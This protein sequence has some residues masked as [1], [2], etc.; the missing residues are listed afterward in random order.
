[1][2][3]TIDHEA[4]LRRLERQNGRLRGTILALAVLGAGP[5]LMASTSQQAPAGVLRARALEVVGP[6]GAVVVRIDSSGPEGTGALT[7]LDAQGNEVVELSAEKD[8]PDRLSGSLE[9]KSGGKRRLGCFSHG[10]AGRVIITDED[11]KALAGIYSPSKGE[12][13]VG[14][15]DAETGVPLSALHSKGRVGQVHTWNA[16]GELLF[17]VG[18]E[19]KGGGGLL[20][21][22][23]GDKPQLTASGSGFLQIWNE[24]GQNLVSLM[25]DEKNGYLSALDPE[26][27]TPVAVLGGNGEIGGLEIMNRQGQKL[28]QITSSGDYGAVMTYSKRGVP[29]IVLASAA[30]VR[31]PKFAICDPEG[32]EI[33]TA[34]LGVVA[35][36]NGRARETGGGT[37]GVRNPHTGMIEFLGY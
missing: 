1:M 20:A 12:A 23:K 31:G 30:Q 35:D 26:T 5:F 28:V 9:L 3:T 34:G 2:N 8:G 15:F 17:R 37:V 13:F 29:G 14:V 33:V 25:C 19:G 22:M 6:E 24:A 36:G 11:D 4:R 32:E 21:L 10:G 16:K 18:S 27:G 7:T